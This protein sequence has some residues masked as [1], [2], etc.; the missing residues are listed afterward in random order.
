[1]SVGAIFT[2]ISNGVSKADAAFTATRILQRRIATILSTRQDGGKK[3]WSR[4]MDDIK[5]THV[6]F[7]E[8]GYKPF[9][10]IAYEYSKASVQRGKCS[11]GSSSEFSIN[12][13]GQFVND[14]ILHVILTNLKTVN[15]TYDKCKY[16]TYLGHRL[17]EQVRFKINGNPID[18]YGT[19][20][21]NVYYEFEVPTDKATG[22]LRNIGQEVPE[23]AYFTPDP[24]V[25]EYREV[26]YFANGPQTFKATHDRVEMWIPLLFEF[27]RRMESSL[28][29]VAIPYGQTDI[30]IKFAPLDVIA[31][32]VTYDA[33]L[34]GNG[35][36]IE[37][38]IKVCELYIN[39]IFMIEEVYSIFIKNYGA[40]VFRVHK[41]QEKLLDLKDGRIVLNS[42]KFP[43]E[44]IFVAFRPQDNFNHFAYW[45]CNSIVTKTAVEIP[46]MIQTPVPHTLAYNDAV[47]YTKVPSV[48]TIGITSHGHTIYQIMNES[49]YNSYT[50]F[51]FGDK[52]NTPK[53]IGWHLINFN[54]KPGEKQPSGYLN[55][56]KQ[57]EFYLVYSAPQAS[58]ANPLRM[59]VVAYV[60]N[61]LL[62]EGGT[63]HLVWST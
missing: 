5:K 28:P 52:W 38:T 54:I 58:K 4:I 42:L 3:H 10:T 30:E 59:I 23:L 33:V 21:Y 22:Y 51:R 45:Y 2:L 17:L 6:I 27:N 9:A 32:G 13:Y 29:N 15:Q 36:I 1:M 46:C 57:R 41:R 20:E 39:H 25:D 55:V 19:E 7:I 48:T 47:W 12:K 24:T 18:E 34:G 50:P 43:L 37:P 61:L 26:K 56:S 62:I 53:G 31:D 40:T 35:V 16:T 63:A 11:F 14:M 44:S 60:I 49:F 8:S